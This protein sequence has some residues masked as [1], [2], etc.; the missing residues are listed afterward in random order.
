[1]RGQC[2]VDDLFYRR[3]RPILSSEGIVGFCK[4]TQPALKGRQ[5]PRRCLI[6]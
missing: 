1:M 2:P 5:G 4:R 3:F 6:P